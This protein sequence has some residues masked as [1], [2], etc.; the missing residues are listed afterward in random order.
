MRIHHSLLIKPS[1]VVQWLSALI[2]S[3]R[4]PSVK[5]GKG[6]HFY[7]AAVFLRSSCTLFFF[8]ASVSEELVICMQAAL[9]LLS[10]ELPVKLKISVIWELCKAHS[11]LIRRDNLWIHNLS[12]E[13]LLGA[14]LSEN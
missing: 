8:F 13:K 3:Q 14:F 2:D 1:E 7:A 10:H 12:V 9:S 6:L 11:E 4:I 5:M